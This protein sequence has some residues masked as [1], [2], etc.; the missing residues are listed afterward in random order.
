M[1]ETIKSYIVDKDLL[2]VADEIVKKFGK[3]SAGIGKPDLDLQE[4][5]INNLADKIILF[6]KEGNYQIKE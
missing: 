2:K 3:E 6:E 1:L 4:V 5:E